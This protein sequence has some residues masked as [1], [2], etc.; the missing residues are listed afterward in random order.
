[1]K[2]KTKNKSDTRGANQYKPDP[3]Q[4]LFLSYYVNPRSETFSN[5]VK[6]ALKAGYSQEYAE[7]ILNQN[8]WISENLKRIKMLEKAE[9]NL[10]ETLD[11]DIEEQAM[12]AFGPIVKKDQDGN[13]TA[14]MRRNPK[15]MAIKHDA[16]KFVAERIGKNYYASR[17]EHTDGDG[18]A[19][20]PLPTDKQRERLKKIL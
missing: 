18:K 5:A 2:K 8:G 7:V 6:S 12:G 14:V 1:M 13:E 9:R 3:R 20:F 17:N 4:S 16:S 11:I 19:L 10:S 15:I